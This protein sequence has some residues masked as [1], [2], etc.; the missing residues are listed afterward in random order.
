MSTVERILPSTPVVD[1]AAYVARFEGGRAVAV[2]RQVPAEAMLAELDAAGLRGR[3]GAGFPTGRKWR[4]VL[5]S[6]SGAVATT[7]VVNG[8]EGE[9]GTFKDRAILRANPYQVIE[10]ALVAALV[11]GADTVVVALKASFGD[12]LGRVR[13]AIAEVGEAGWAEGI[14]ITVAEG[15]GEYLFGEETALLEVLDGRAPLPR[16]APPY[17]RGV[18][19]VVVDIDD[20][21][22]HSGLAAPVQMA[23]E[24]PENVAPPTLVDNVETLANIPHIALHGAAWFRRVGTP[25]S[26][27]TIVCTI[28]GQVE[29]PGV[30]EIALGTTLRQAIDEVAGGLVPGSTVTAVLPGVSNAMLG[31]EALDTP[32]TYE[33]LSALGSGLGSAGFIV[34]D[35]SDD[36]VAAAAGAS[37]FLAVES[38]GQCTPCKQDGLVLARLLEQVSRSEAS[39]DDLATLQ[40]RV[41]TVADGARCNLAFQQQAI[42][43]GLLDHFED[44]V[45]AHLDGTAPARDPLMIAELTELTDGDA[46]VDSHRQDKQPDWTYDEA[47]S[48]MAPADRLADHRMPTSR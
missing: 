38:C 28:T 19:E 17:R 7:V 5:A 33:A 26:P 25:D 34:L 4:T 18:D 1:L 9:P 22:R 36:V 45:A 20:S 6:R 2:A 16:I 42:V 23:G 24:Q 3:G 8:A 31:P 37:R 29:R 14:S 32:L 46:V 39:R 44:E 41:S 30:G 43:E 27:G 21:E 35:Q 15:P 10:G 47:D 12:E 13:R 48:G 40:D 11:V